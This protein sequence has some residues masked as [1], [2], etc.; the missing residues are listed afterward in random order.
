MGNKKRQAREDVNQNVA[1]IFGEMIE[2]SEQPPQRG[3][4]K[5]A[6][7]PAKKERR[8]VERRM[9]RTRSGPLVVMLAT[10]TSS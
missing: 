1:R 2:R 5:I 7:P 8:E 9:A 4:M 10:V 6:P 3:N